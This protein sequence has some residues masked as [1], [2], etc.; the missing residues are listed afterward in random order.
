VTLYAS[1]KS[2][3][4]KKKR[5]PKKPA[6]KRKKK[7]AHKAKSARKTSVRKRR[8]SQSAKRGSQKARQRKVTPRKR[9]ARKRSVAPTK[10]PA[11]KRTA[12]KRLAKKRT[13]VKRAAAKRPT[14]TKRP[15]AKVLA[16]RKAERA[17][18]AKRDKRNKARRD[19]AAKRRAVEAKQEALRLQKEA[20]R[21]KNPKTT[22]R[23]LEATRTEVDK[24]IAV[25][26]K[27]VSDLGNTFD[28]LFEIAEKTGQL[29][30]IDYDSTRIFSKKT[31]GQ[32][33][34]VRIGSLVTEE[35]VE[36]ILYK[37]N[38]AAKRL[39]GRRI[40]LA[41]TISS[42]LGDRS[43]GGSGQ[44][45]LNSADPFAFKFQPEQYDSTGVHNTRDQMMGAFERLL[46]EWADSDQRSLVYL[47]SVL[48]M[49]WTVRIS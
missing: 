23:K 32:K 14:A 15:S 47:H 24:Q 2:R 40:W 33:K 37:V 18:Q 43:A 17:E 27:A 8:T 10:R 21:L 12:V 5:E 29:P 30:D 19:I 6:S 38:Q 41:T 39:S 34:M 28:R 4:R 9:P 25:P 20:L 31:V 16:K 11:K 13:A 22:R 46:N 35:T 49:H 26:P 3:T 45:V 36:E 42:S 48:V 44:R 1:K 7:L